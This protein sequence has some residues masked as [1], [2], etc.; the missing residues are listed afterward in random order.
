LLDDRDGA[1]FRTFETIIELPAKFAVA[2]SADPRATLQ[3]TAHRHAEHLDGGQPRRD[4]TGM[5]PA[6]AAS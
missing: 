4:L 6:P 1:D 3:H 5:L 2:G